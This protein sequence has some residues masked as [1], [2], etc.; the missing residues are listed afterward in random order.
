MLSITRRAARFLILVAAWN[1]IIWLDFARR[2]SGDDGRPTSFYVVHA[3]L[4]GTSL[5]L[6]TAVGLI[7]WRALRTPPD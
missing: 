3:V 7:G 1:W 4:I 6:A 5:V 2:L